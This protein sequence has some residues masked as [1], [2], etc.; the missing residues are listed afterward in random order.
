MTLSLVCDQLFHIP[1]KCQGLGGHF[2]RV[3]SVAQM[4]GSHGLSASLFTAVFFTRLLFDL[5]YMGRRKVT[6]ISI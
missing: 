6:A 4:Q 5:L 3:D 1:S 2:H